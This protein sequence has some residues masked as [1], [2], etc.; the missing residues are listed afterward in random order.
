MCPTDSL[1]FTCEL[2]EVAL[3]RVVLPTG[4]QEV[5]SIGETISYIALPAGFNAVSLNIK[6]IDEITRTFSL[7]ISIVNASLLG[8][9]EMRCDDTTLFNTAVSGC[10][11]YGKFK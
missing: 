3:L 5:M 8:G 10:Q 9:G 4:D 11:L 1:L 6:E 7:K 2:S